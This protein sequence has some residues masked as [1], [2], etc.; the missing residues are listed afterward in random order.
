MRYLVQK[1]RMESTNAGEI[2][3]L[4]CF[5]SVLEGTILVALTAS[6]DRGF[7]F[8]RRPIYLEKMSLFENPTKNIFGVSL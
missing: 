6:T 1:Q 4:I 3:L 2:N 5:P 7:H 8:F